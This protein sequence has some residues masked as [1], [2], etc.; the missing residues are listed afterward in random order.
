MNIICR[1]NACDSVSAAFLFRRI[2]VSRSASSGCCF[3]SSEGQ[4]RSE[5]VQT[6]MLC[7][8]SYSRTR[9]YIIDLIMIIVYNYRELIRKYT[10]TNSIKVYIMYYPTRRRSKSSRGHIYR[11]VPLFV[12]LSGVDEIMANLYKILGGTLYGDHSDGAFRNYFRNFI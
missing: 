2:V 12:E 11:T 1:R 8:A 3:N 6:V 5:Q 10:C 9:R 7:V 4:W